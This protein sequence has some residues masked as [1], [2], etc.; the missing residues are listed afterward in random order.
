MK[1]TDL[2]EQLRRACVSFSSEQLPAEIRYLDREG[3]VVVKP[4]LEATVDEIVFC[5]QSVNTERSS[6]SHRAL[7]LEDVLAYAR[8]RRYLGADR[9]G[10]IAAEVTK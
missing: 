6:L 3:N 2:I 10:D 5:L 9:I 4:L 1:V 7:V 8:Q